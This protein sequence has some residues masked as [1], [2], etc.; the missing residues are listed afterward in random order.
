MTSLNCIKILSISQPM[1][2]AR[3]WVHALR[4]SQTTLLSICDVVFDDSIRFCSSD[5]LSVL[6]NT[7]G[8]VKAE[9]LLS[10]RAYQH[11]LHHQAYLRSALRHSQNADVR[12]HLTLSDRT[13]DVRVQAA[14]RFGHL[15]GHPHA[16]YVAID[17]GRERR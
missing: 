11:P 8:K 6:G 16:C 17:L 3:N 10:L 13:S 15:P 1:H 14:I 7:H 9:L 12:V 4:A 2:A 5:V